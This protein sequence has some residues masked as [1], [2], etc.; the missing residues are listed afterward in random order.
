MAGVG[1]TDLFPSDLNS[2]TAVS[3]IRL[4]VI[5]NVHDQWDITCEVYPMLVA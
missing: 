5:L 4:V 1:L 2:I 3:A